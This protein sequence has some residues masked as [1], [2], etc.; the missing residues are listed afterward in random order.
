MVKCVH[1]CEL[2]QYPIIAV[3]ITRPM[4]ILF[5]VLL[6]CNSIVLLHS[7]FDLDLASNCS[8]RWVSKQ[9]T[10]KKDSALRPNLHMRLCCVLRL[11][12]S[13]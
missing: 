5:S 12:G 8:S 13:H 4:D 6:F 10:Y 11:T 2:Q 1:G 3:R 7:F 9:L